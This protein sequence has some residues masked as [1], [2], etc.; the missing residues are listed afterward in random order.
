MDFQV[1]EIPSELIEPF[2][3]KFINSLTH[4]IAMGSKTP[5]I[6]KQQIDGVNFFIQQ[7]SGIHGR[8]WFSKHT[9]DLCKITDRDLYTMCREMYEMKVPETEAEW[10]LIESH[11]KKHD[12]KPVGSH[13]C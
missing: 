11:W 6:A 5:Q 1:K 3:V 9:F 7:T 8:L 12:E 10:E 4:G 2:C 13:I